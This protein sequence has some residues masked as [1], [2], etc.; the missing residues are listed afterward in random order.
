MTKDEAWANQNMW[1]VTTTIDEI[2]DRIPDPRHCNMQLV[3]FG[4][5]LGYEAALAEMQDEAQEEE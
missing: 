3:K 4:F 1:V 2:C 5:E